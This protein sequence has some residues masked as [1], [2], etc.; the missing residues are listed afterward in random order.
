M[1]KFI[2]TPLAKELEEH[3]NL[4]H[5]GSLDFTPRRGTSGSQGYDL[6]AC[7]EAE[8][9]IYPGDRIKIPV[10]VHIWLDNGGKPTLKGD[11]FMLGGF[12]LPRGS[13]QGYMINLLDSDYQGELFIIFRNGLNDLITIKP[14]QAI[15][16]LAI[17]PCYIWD[18]VEVDSFEEETERSSNCLGHTGE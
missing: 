7:I 6:R 3:H 16:Q 9:T 14:G 11:P 18:M 4:Q 17:V 10:G 8:Q 2:K 1:I 13:S 12:I 15:A 5:T